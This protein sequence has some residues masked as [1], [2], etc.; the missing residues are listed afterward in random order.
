[1]KHTEE[2]GTVGNSYAIPSLKFTAVEK[3]IFCKVAKDDGQ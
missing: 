2:N 1:M 3:I